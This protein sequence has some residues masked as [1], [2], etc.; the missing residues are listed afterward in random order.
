MEFFTEDAYAQFLMKELLPVIDRYFSR[1]F[2]LVNLQTGEVIGEDLTDQYDTKSYSNTLMDRCLARSKQYLFVSSSDM[3]DSPIT[4]KDSI[5]FGARPL[6][7]WPLPEN[8][9]ASPT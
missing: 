8:P 3:P 7:T 6:R 2:Q 5:F 4:S 9:R 1:G